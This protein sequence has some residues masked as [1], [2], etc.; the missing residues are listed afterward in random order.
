MTGGASFAI[1]KA[2][3]GRPDGLRAFMC[4]CPVPHHGRGW[5][6]RNPSLRI[7]EET[8]GT[9]KLTCLAKCA[10]ADVRRHV[11][12]IAARRRISLPAR[13]PP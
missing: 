4:R 10:E 3:S 6:D 7:R 2:L 9:I 1:A 8:D 13:A 12:R 11:E 5:G